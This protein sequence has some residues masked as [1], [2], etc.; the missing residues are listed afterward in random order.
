MASVNVESEVTGKVWK[1]E[2][3]VGDNVSEGDVLMILESMKM[4]IPVESPVSGIVR[5]LLVRKD[6]SIDEDQVIA[7]IEP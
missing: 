4:E 5:E 2:A 7:V 6:D 1:I 3:N